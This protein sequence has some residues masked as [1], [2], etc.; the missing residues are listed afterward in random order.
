MNGNS[1]ILAVQEGVGF[2]KFNGTTQIHIRAPGAGENIG[3]DF[4]SPRGSLFKKVFSSG[5]P[6][7]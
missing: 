1:S 3:R 6:F 4:F 5:R 2:G 7:F